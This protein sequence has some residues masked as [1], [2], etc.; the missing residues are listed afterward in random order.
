MEVM[1][2]EFPVV[3]G[4]ARAGI[5]GSA[6]Y[7]IADTGMLAHV[8]GS[9][10]GITEE[11]SLVWVDRNGNEESLGIRSGAYR[12]PRIS[13]DG[14]NLALTIDSGNKSDIWTCDVVNKNPI[15]LTTNEASICPLWTLDG[16]RIAFLSGDG[17]AVYWRAADGTGVDELIGS[18][19][20]EATFPF[21]WSIDENMLITMEFGRGT[22]L[23][24]GSLSMEEDHPHKPLLQGAHVELQP[25]I[26]PDG[27]WMAYA[28]NESGEIQIYVRP[29]PEVN[30]GGPWM[31][32]TGGGANPLW[33]P[34]GKE[35][36][37]RVNND[38]IAVSVET[39]QIFKPVKSEILF[40][41]NYVSTTSNNFNSWDIH[42]N[43]Q[44]FL[45][46]KESTGDTTTE[47]ASRPRI[48]IIANWFEELKKKVPVE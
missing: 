9:E 33:S 45:M 10:G 46:M 7:G 12:Y 30:S 34:D 47:E 36:F 20:G 4:V 32:S 39:E 42:P 16:K 2:G 18:G 38:V 27:R 28:S 14:T 5:T 44:R 37:Y 25:R 41:G 19:P 15:R 3:E 35:L 8:V 22:A 48:N 21:A 43:G 26:S 17:G 31:V 13:P 40:R 6:N 11:R 24:I 23:D 1:G 29:F